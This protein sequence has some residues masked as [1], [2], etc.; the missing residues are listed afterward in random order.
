MYEIIIEACELYA[1]VKDEERLED[2][3]SQVELCI[4]NDCLILAYCSQVQ[5]SSNLIP[6]PMIHI[7]AILPLVPLLVHPFEP[8]CDKAAHMEN[9]VQL[10]PDVEIVPHFR[11]YLANFMSNEPPTSEVLTLEYF[12]ENTCQVDLTLSVVLPLCQV[13]LISMPFR[14]Y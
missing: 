5:D 7:Q 14:L 1:S 10:P 11:I 9:I 8:D 6:S 4:A 2:E 12:D 3:T 13:L